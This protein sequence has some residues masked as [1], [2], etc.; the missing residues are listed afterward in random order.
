MREQIEVFKIP[1]QCVSLAE[2]PTN[3]NGKYDRRQVAEL[4]ARA[5]L[6]SDP[7]S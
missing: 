7:E 2:I 3:G 6:I 5:G 4:L 1:R